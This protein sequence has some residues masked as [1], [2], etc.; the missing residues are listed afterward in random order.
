MISIQHSIVFPSSLPELAIHSTASAAPSFWMEWISN[1][2]IGREVGGHD[3]QTE[4][5]SLVRFETEPSGPA[6]GSENHEWIA[7]ATAGELCRPIKPWQSVMAPVLCLLC[8]DLL[9]R[10]LSKKS[11]VIRASAVECNFR[12]CIIHHWK[13]SRTDCMILWRSLTAAFVQENMV[14]NTIPIQMQTTS[15][16]PC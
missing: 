16:N 9:N 4:R 8:S 5:A 7:A 14:S 10:V 12:E 13:G 3:R 15:R 1:Y 11:A 6:N 2:Q